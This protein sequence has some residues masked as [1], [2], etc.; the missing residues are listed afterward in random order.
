MSIKPRHSLK[1]PKDILHAVYTSLRNTDSIDDIAIPL[2]DSFYIK[3][4]IKAKLGIDKSVY[5]IEA[6]LYNEGLLSYK[7]YG[8]PQWYASKYLVGVEKANEQAA[9][10]HIHSTATL[11]KKN[12]KR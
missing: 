1:H 8:I 12:N 11:H 2:S 9:R 10:K 4:H 6:C 5:E 3:A 7:S